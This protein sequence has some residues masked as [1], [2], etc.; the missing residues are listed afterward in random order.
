M[1]P[2]M[3]KVELLCLGAQTNVNIDKGRKSGAGP[4]GGRYSLLPD[5][6]CLDLPLQGAFVEKSPFSLIQDERGFVLLKNGEFYTR[7]D[8]IPY[9]SFYE[10]A[11]SDGVLMQ[12]IAI[13]HGKDCLAST[14]YSRCIYWRSQRQCKFCGIELWRGKPVIELKTARQL[15]E[16][17]YQAQKEGVANHV[18]LTT[19][20]PPTPDKGAVFLAEAT[21]AIKQSTN[22]PVHVQIEPPKNGKWLETLYDAGVDTV[23]I[24]VETFDEKVLSQVCPMKPSLK[25]FFAAWK[26]AVKL[27]GEGQVSSFLIA[28]LGESDESIYKGAIELANLGVIPY[29]L[30]L[31]PIRGTALENAFPPSPERMIRLYE[32]VAQTLHSFGLDPQKNRA[33]CVR[34]GA[35]SAI[36]EAFKYFT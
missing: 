10:K 17:A 8:I 2:F 22:L 33:G 25:E 12:R 36:N 3:I 24:H 16:V 28:G 4:A 21:K 34:C 35:C 11:T 6:T 9:P 13:L 26:K 14:V 19:G 7:L 1:N 18:T 29:L 31:R 20:T 30:P 27:F 5:G 23:G 15:G 32:T